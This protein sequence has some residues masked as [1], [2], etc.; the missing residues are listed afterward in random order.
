LNVIV[1]TT[2]LTGS[3]VLAGLLARAGLW[4]GDATV[5]KEYD[6]FEN[7]ELANLNKRLLKEAGCPIDYSTEFSWRALHTVCAARDRIDLGPYRDFVLRLRARTPW[8]L[9]DPRL[10]LTI[11]FW[12]QLLSFDDV[13]FVWL[14]REP[15]QGWI[16]AT[17]RRIVMSYGYFRQYEGQINASIEAFLELNA[18]PYTHVSFEQLLLVPEGT[19]DKLNNFLDL[20][21]T[22]EDL[23]S[24]YNRP[25]YRKSRGLR[26]F[27]VA[28]AI[29]GKNYFQRVEVD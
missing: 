1:L 17:T 11:R 14:T 7:L 20:K 21:L 24:V 22:L 9:K 19:L 25:L 26:D 2:G 10:W 23:K 16:S 3:S 29:Y 12:Q 28:S 6:T 13:R 5:L 27:L 18:L 15:L 8:I 4:A